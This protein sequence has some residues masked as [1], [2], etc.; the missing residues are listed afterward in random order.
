MEG[1][2]DLNNP[3][4]ERHTKHPRG[5]VVGLPIVSSTAV[6]CQ[7]G[8]IA[9]SHLSCGRGGHMFAYRVTFPPNLG[10]ESLVHL[11]IHG[12]SN[13]PKAR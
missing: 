1:N 11:G 13:D 7:N 12:G 4:R 5:F 6:G 2:A 8:V 9:G 3:K 10:M